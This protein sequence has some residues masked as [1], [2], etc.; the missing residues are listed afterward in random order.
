MGYLAMVKGIEPNDLTER[1]EN[2]AAKYN[3]EIF[4]PTQ[5]IKNGAYR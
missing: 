5:M 2:I 1:L 4:K 3:E